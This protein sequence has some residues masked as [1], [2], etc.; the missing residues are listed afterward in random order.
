MYTTLLILLALYSAASTALDFYIDPEATQRLY[1]VKTRGIYYIRDG[2]VNAY[3][4]N[5]KDQVCRC[6]VS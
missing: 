2:V 5:F 6:H 1:G 3:A 4:M